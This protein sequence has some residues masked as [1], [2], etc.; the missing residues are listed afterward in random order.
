MK[1]SSSNIA[2]YQ[3]DAFSEEKFRGNPAAVCLLETSAEESWMQA[4]AAEMNLSETAFLWPQKDGFQLR[5]FTPTVEVDLCGHATL[6]SAHVL[7]EFNKVSS[8]KPIHFHT[9]S[10]L[11]I[12]QQ[13]DGSLVMDF[14]AEPAEEIPPLQI[15]LSILDL[16]PLYTGRTRSNLLV[17]VR[18]E[19]QLYDFKADADTLLQIP[20]E[21]IILTSETENPDFD[22]VSRFFAPRCGILED[23]VTGS[24]HC[25][26]GPYWAP[27]RGNNKMVAY[28]ASKRGGI[29]GVQV[30]GD[31]VYLTG[32]AVTVMV[33][34]L[35]D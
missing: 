34:A 4:V 32:K 8:N 7:Y 12:V 15:L 31:R 22:F 5:W 17:H 24:A 16:S 29:V 13:Q 18:E 30:D 9:K 33:G 19:Q 28:Q 23:P 6:A 20:M 14:P 21:G 2:L 25:C 11:L 10:G 27:K 1:F 35:I 3:V 26:L